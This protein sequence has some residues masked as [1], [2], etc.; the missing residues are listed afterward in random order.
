[1]NNIL[2]LKIELEDINPK[3]W[4]RFLV[5]NNISF[6]DLHNIIQLVMGWENYH[7]FEFNINNETI[8]S[9]KEGFNPAEGS[10]RKLFQ[11]PEFIKMLEQQDPNKGS[12][13]LDVTKI[14]KILKN[15]EKNKPKI[16]FN[17][18]SKI[19][20]LIKSSGQKFNYLY[21]FSDNWEHT[22]TVEKILDEKDVQECPFCLAGERAYPPEDCG[23]VNGY[24]ELIKIKKNRKHPEYE[25]R[26]IEW[27]GEDFDFEL[28]DINFIN[29]KLKNIVRNLK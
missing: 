8:S 3:I 18:D 11:S 16:K 24:Y 6:H 20:E 14:N 26:I 17:I 13:I 22:I 2:Q 12:G 1:M 15:A 27:L 9:G 5:K 25:E 29:K 21:D 4:R 10:F 7:M 19:S 28:I 23:G